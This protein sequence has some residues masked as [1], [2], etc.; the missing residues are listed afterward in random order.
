M[1]GHEEAQPA[2]GPRPWSSAMQTRQGEQDGGAL[3]RYK[4]GDAVRVMHGRYAGRRGTIFA[5]SPRHAPRYLVKLGRGWLG[6]GWYVQF[7]EDDLAP[8]HA[9]T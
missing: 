5:V 3:R 1:D 4:K 6:R 9:G 8:D 7:P 2:P